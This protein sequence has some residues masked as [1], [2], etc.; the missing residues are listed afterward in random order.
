MKTMGVRCAI[1]SAFILVHVEAA[2][3]TV[4]GARLDRS[5]LPRACA[6]PPPRRRPACVCTPCHP[7]PP[8]RS[9][10][11]AD[12]ARRT[13]P[14]AGSARP[15]NSPRSSPPSF[16]P[17]RGACSARWVSTPTPATS[18]A[19]SGAT[20]ARFSPGHTA[21]SVRLGSTWW[22]LSCASAGNRTRA[23]C[24]RAVSS[25]TATGSSSATTAR[26][27]SSLLPPAQDRATSATATR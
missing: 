4:R 11:R 9:A 27:G 25:R 26:L 7:P 19:V 17:A 1:L 12:T 15:V 8:P 21:S 22:R 13:T 5:V 18:S 20:P 23:T 16:A 14:S 24:A 6:Y 10:A 3:R 2:L